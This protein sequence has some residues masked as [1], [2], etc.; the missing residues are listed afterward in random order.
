MGPSNC[1]RY[2]ASPAY[3]CLDGTSFAHGRMAV[4]SPPP[5]ASWFGKVVAISSRFQAPPLVID[6]NTLSTLAE[7]QVKRRLCQYRVEVVAPLVMKGLHHTLAVPLPWAWISSRVTSTQDAAA[8]HA[9]WSW[10]C[11]SIGPGAFPECSL[12]NSA[13]APTAEH[14]CLRCSWVATLFQQDTCDHY[15]FAQ[16]ALFERPVAPSMFTAQLSISRRIWQRLAS[17]PSTVQTK[18]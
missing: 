8:F 10:R 5:R 11:F 7:A 13:E 15:A 4:A 12:C 2:Y 1:C 14:L 6:F 17:H 16:E 3:A 18:S 9:W